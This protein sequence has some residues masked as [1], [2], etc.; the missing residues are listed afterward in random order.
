MNHPYFKKSPRE[1]RRV[2]VRVGAA[3]I[4]IVFLSLLLAWVTRFSLLPFIMIPI[5]L[6]IAAPFI[7]VP[8]LK[9]SDKLR[10]FSPLFVAEK[11]KDGIMKIHGGSL[12]D[13]YFVLDKMM[14][15]KER[16]DFILLQ[17]IEG[18]LELIEVY[19]EKELENLTVRGTSYIINR[20]TAE[21]FGF[22]VV[23]TDILQRFILTFNYF[24]ILISYSLAKRK[25]S[26]PK[27]SSTITFEAKLDT[28]A[29]RKELL[30]EL[31]NRMQAQS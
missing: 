26:F 12:F 9:K 21:R 28:L 8:A 16:I 10:Y 27:I 22:E 11:P 31:R 4:G 19:E 14:N 2:Q 24:N 17:F 6:S 13:Y 7:D 25:L 30:L 18:L 20:R 3:V 15:G 1:Q 5:A 23:Q 29:E